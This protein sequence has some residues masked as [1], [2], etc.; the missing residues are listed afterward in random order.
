[1]GPPSQ[2]RDASSN[3]ADGMK[4]LRLRT[5][6]G[7]R[8]RWTNLRGREPRG[9]AQQME[10]IAFDAHKHYTLASVVRPDGQ[11]VREERIE[12]DRGSLREF[13]DRCER[14]SPVAV[15]TI[16]NWYW[17]VDE[18]EAAGCVPKLVHPRKAKLV[19][20]GINKTGRLDLRGVNRLR[21]NRT[22][23]TVWLPPRA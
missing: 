16:G 10:Y 1:M 13:L 21:R 17:I 23:A 7:Y 12:H 6:R 8:V 18:I 4:A 2:D 22:P 9:E 20:G 19:V 5:R 3:P 15:G 14:G 11:L